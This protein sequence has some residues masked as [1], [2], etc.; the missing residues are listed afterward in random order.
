VIVG[1]NESLKVLYRPEAGHSLFTYFMCA[2]VAGS[3]AAMATIPLDNI[4]T[5][6]QTQTFFEDA[7]NDKV[8]PDYPFNS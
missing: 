7:R 3:S 8:R 1:V 5:R 4:K 6:L 2:L